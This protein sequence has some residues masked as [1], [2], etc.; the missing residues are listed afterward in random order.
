MP[1][2]NELN[3]PQFSVIIPVYN[4]EPH[5]ARSISSVLNQSFDNFELIIVCD[6]STDNSNKQ[7]DKFTDSRI[8]VLHRDQ[9]GPGGYAARNLG[10]DEARAEWVAFLD[11]DDEWLGDHL[12]SLNNLLSKNPKYDFIA[13]SFIEIG[14]VPRVIGLNPKLGV[15]REFSFEHYLTYSPF[16]TSCVLCKKK[17][18]LNVGA[19]PDGK[20]SRGGDV[21]TWLR[22]IEKAGGYIMSAHLG[23]KYYKNTV[24]MITRN[25]FY[26]DQEIRN[27]SIKYFIEKY[28]NTKTSKKLMKKW[29]NHVIYAWNQ[30]MHLNVEKNFDLNGKLFFNIFHL[31]AFAFYMLSNLPM[32][33]LKPLHRK[34]FFFVRI[35]RN[36]FKRKITYLIQS[37]QM[38]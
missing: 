37:I 20:M 10:L 13:A 27:S 28:K 15:Y 6:P 2:V 18:L 38:V 29:N 23:A 30:N 17:L 7:V 31:K 32:S 33:F 8:K 22:A 1:Q 26:G 3:V 21:D 35:K 25:F 36:L 5:I 24:N 11:A 14:E 12:K 34:L 9:P 16:Y 19:F 4:K